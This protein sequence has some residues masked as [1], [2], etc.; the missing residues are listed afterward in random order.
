MKKLAA[1]I[2]ILFDVPVSAQ[3]IIQPGSFTLS[4][5]VMCTPVKDQSMSSTCWSF[6]GNSFLESEVLRI[7]G[8]N[9]DLSEMYI[10]RYSYINKFRR[11]LSEDG[12]I[13]FTPGGQF[14]DIIRVIRQYGIVPEAAYSGR[15]NGALQHNHSEL[16]TVM[17]QYAESLLRKKTRSLSSE[18]LYHIN[19][20]LDKYLGKVPATFKYDGKTYTPK[21]FTSEYLKF[22][23][24]DYVE[25]TSYTHH[26]FYETFVLEDKYNW[27]GDAYY[28]VPLDDFMRITNS[29]IEKNYSVCWDGDVT[30]DGFRF[31]N[32]TAVLKYPVTD[33]ISE[34]QRTYE[35][36]SSKLD[37][38][39]HVTGIAK[40][41][42]NGT[43]Y[44]V[45][46]SW[47]TFNTTGGYV[48]MS[49]D[50]FKIKTIAIIVNRKAIPQDI[51]QKL[52]L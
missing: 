1:F 14:H 40:D 17:K 26:P 6:A 19:S 39:M 24:D 35:D 38:M 52:K 51:L 21:S 48:L 8:V 30:E 27:T 41:R 3:E 7:K 13:Y 9:T 11:F 10:A 50:Y 18:Q 37:H 5:Q 2:L 16:D 22:N 25:I 42:E 23:A 36:K 15:V 12:K 20:I 4:R 49:E 32:S 31:D 44:M 43:W 29:A 28:N 45:K 46:N 34:R 47:G 33:F